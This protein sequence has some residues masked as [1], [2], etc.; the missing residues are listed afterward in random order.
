MLFVSL[1]LRDGM[2]ISIGEKYRLMYYNSTGN[3]NLCHWKS[4]KFFMSLEHGERGFLDCNSTIS[5]PIDP[6]PTAVDARQQR[7]PPDAHTF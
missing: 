1:P 2:A 4:Q 5:C 3:S 7:A 6:P